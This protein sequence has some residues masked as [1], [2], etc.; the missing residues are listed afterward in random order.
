MA[1]VSLGQ[2]RIDDSLL[3][4]SS[5]IPSPLISFSFNVLLILVGTITG[6]LQYRLIG[7]LAACLIS[8]A[9]ARPMPGWRRSPRRF[10]SL[11]AC[12]F[13]AQ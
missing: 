4:T 8:K 5:T 11:I 6:A 12:I 1:A 10:H 13:Q 2:Q 9:T 7:S 3:V